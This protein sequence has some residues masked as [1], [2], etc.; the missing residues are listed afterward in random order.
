MNDE[1]KKIFFFNSNFLD[2]S[3]INSVVNKTKDLSK[4]EREKLVSLKA[5]N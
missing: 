3:Q 1:T 2:Q 5:K 4:E